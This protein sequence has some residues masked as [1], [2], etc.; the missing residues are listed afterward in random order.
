MRLTTFLFTLIHLLALTSAAMTGNFMSMGS[1]Y[2]TTQTTIQR[3]QQLA[4]HLVPNTS[5]LNLTGLNLTNL[6]LDLNLNLTQLTNRTGPVVD[7]AKPHIARA[8]NAT[9]DYVVKHPYQTIFSIVGVFYPA[10][11]LRL[12]GYGPLGP[13]ARSLAAWSQT[14]WGNP[15]ARSLRAC[16]Q[17]AAMNGYAAAPV[18]NTVRGVILSTGGYLAWKD[19]FGNT[20]IKQQR[21][22]V[23]CCRMIPMTVSYGIGKISASSDSPRTIVTVGASPKSVFLLTAPSVLS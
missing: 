6:N 22:K 20:A 3:L 14:Y 12:V 1:V 9:K 2:N 8:G 18:L 23:W 17:S 5:S 4:G 21:V 16:L 11:L 13:C 19:G 15:V 7:A 10:W